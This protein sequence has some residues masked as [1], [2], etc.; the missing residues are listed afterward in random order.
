MSS[1]EAWKSPGEHRPGVDSGRRT[2]TDPRSEQDLGAAGHRDLLVLRAA[3]RDVM[4]GKKGVGAER[5]TALR[6]GKALQG[7]P[8]EWYRPSRSEGAGGSKPSGG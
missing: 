3:G 1:E 7:E 2:G 5:R 8:H 4:N 6:G